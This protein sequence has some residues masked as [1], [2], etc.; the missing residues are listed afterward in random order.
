MFKKGNTRPRTE[1][2]KPVKKSLTK[3]LLA[4]VVAIVAWVGL[5]FVESYVLMDK[6]VSTVIV[7][8]VDIPEGTVLNSDNINEYVTKKEVNSNLVTSTT[9]V[10][11]DQIKGKTLVNI[12]AGEIMT[13]TRYKDLSYVED[14]LKD[15][16]EV[17]FSVSTAN[18]ANNG[19]IRE[20]D[21]V[22]IYASVDNKDNKSEFQR[23][24]ENVYIDGAYDGSFAKINSA[25]KSVA[26]TNFVIKMEADDVASFKNYT[27]NG[28]VILV[29]K[30]SKD[31]VTSVPAVTDQTESSESTEST[32]TVDQTESTADD[33]VLNNQNVVQSI[34]DSEA[35]ED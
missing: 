9:I 25:D 26:A 33:T 20:G 13:S 16:T 30:D 1:E 22:D 23:I 21:L 8:S 31:A 29:K 17:S 2:Q 28:T 15:P 12:S 18:N 3:A 14:D 6:N 24:R 27:E 35:A 4:I 32:E 19:Y 5:T 10:D 34:K 7:A 11:A